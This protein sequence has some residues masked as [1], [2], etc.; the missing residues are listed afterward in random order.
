MTAMDWTFPPGTGDSGMFEIGRRLTEHIGHLPDATRFTYDPRDMLRITRQIE[1]ACRGATLWVGFQSADKLAHERDRYEAL[2]ASG[3][4]VTGYG[5][6]EAPS[7]LE[8][9]DYRRQAPDTRRLANQWF[10]V[11]TA[12]EPIAFVS[13]ELGDPALFGVGGA[14]APGKRFVGFV[15]DDPSVVAELTAA[16]EAVGGLT[17]PTPSGPPP[18]LVAGTRAGDLLAA[19]SRL[20]PPP[21]NAPDGAV[22]VPVGRGQDG[23]L[24]LAL[25]IALREERPVVL[26][27][28][29]A[30]GWLG[31]PYGDLRGD[32]DYRPDPER[33]FGVGLA[34]REGRA[35]A[36][37]GLEAAGALGVK[38]GGWFP[39]TA[40]GGGLSEA[41]RRFGG[42]LLVVPSSVRRPGLAERLR[43][44]S[45]ER[46]G[47]LGVHLVIAD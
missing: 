14:A 45:A 28:R 13:W 3:T 19:V 1:A 23:A 31:T 11:S 37:M 41:V 7:G 32:D 46:L 12:P 35:D 43:G 17:T 22:V 16:L 33:L 8:G 20:E 26:V 27:D 36:A 34:L 24:A 44:M 2:V 40:G 5:T 29:G 30:E 47:E 18:P 9:L 6:G 39:T 42:S 10:L 38:A 21:S 4:R 15:S 25:A